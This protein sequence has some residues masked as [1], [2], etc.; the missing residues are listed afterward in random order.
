MYV[1]VISIVLLVMF[2]Y[3]PIG[4]F[5]YMLGANNR[6]AELTGISAK[7]Y[8]PL[9]FIVSGMITAFAGFVLGAKLQVATPA[10][11]PDYLLPAFVGAL[12]GSTAISRAASTCSAPWSRCSSSRLPSPAF[13]SSVRSSSPSRCSTAR[14]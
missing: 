10:V 5:L 1:I 6:A 13:S 3:L 14:C 4:R 11:G 7:R 9:A 8:I 12:L 2:E